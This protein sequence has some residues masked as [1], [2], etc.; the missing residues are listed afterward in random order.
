MLMTHTVLIVLVVSPYTFNLHT[1]FLTVLS[2]TRPALNPNPNPK[3]NHN[4]TPNPNPNRNPNL[5]LNPIPN[6]CPKLNTN[7]DLTLPL[8]LRPSPH[9]P[10][11]GSGEAPVMVVWRKPKLEAKHTAFGAFWW[12]CVVNDN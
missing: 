9:R 3:H 12:R 2:F 6:A 7:A 11:G 1:T 10:W 4:L 8:I 5:D